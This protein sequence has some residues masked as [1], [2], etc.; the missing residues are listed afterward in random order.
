MCSFG[1][2]RNKR[3]LC[4]RHAEANNPY[5][6]LAIFWEAGIKL[7]QENKDQKAPVPQN[8]PKAKP[9]EPPKP[10]RMESISYL[11]KLART[12]QICKALE[13]THC[14]PAEYTARAP[15]GLRFWNPDWL[16]E[17]PQNHNQQS[18][19]KIKIIQ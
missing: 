1:L 14:M 6:Y 19:K 7:H 11:L 5:P 13:T 18:Y 10:N 17:V 12:S 16:P 2:T 8:I 15:K 9:K 4:K 3:R